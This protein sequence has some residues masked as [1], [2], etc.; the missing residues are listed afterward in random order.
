[1]NIEKNNDKKHY[2]SVSTIYY[3]YIYIIKIL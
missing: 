3:I 2:N 1:M